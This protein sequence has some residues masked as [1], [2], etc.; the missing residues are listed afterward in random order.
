MNGVMTERKFVAMVLELA[1]RVG[2]RRKEINADYCSALV[3]AF[4]GIDNPC[5]L[6]NMSCAEGVVAGKELRE[7][8]LRLDGKADDDRVKEEISLILL[9][10]ASERIPGD[11]VRR[12][13]WALRHNWEEPLV[14]AEVA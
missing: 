4:Y 2:R 10:D 6:R 5:H 7:L 13:G 11:V 8:F 14:G 1:K 3:N 12:A 9:P